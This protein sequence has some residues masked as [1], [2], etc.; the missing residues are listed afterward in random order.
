MR[1]ADHSGMPA[2]PYDIWHWKPCCLVSSIS[3]LIISMHNDDGS[4]HS[5]GTDIHAGSLDIVFQAKPFLVLRMPPGPPSL[6]VS[7]HFLLRLC[8][9]QCV[10][11]WPANIDNLTEWIWEHIQGITKEMPQR[12][13]TPFPLWLQK[14]TEWSDGQLQSSKLKQ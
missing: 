9:K 4:N 3:L 5:H 14:C 13:M 11:M 10:Q 2:I 1:W 8:E 12:V 6:A 7:D